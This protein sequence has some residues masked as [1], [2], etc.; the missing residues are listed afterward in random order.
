MKNKL[1]WRIV[2]NK[3]IQI[4]LSLIVIIVFSIMF[5]ITK[6]KFEIGSTDDPTFQN[7]SYLV[8]LFFSKPTFGQRGSLTEGYKSLVYPFGFISLLV[9]ILGGGAITHYRIQLL[10]HLLLMI[11]PVFY[12]CKRFGSLFIATLVSLAVMGTN[13]FYEQLSYSIG[14]SQVVLVAFAIWAVLAPS[15]TC[16]SKFNVVAF[17]ALSTSVSLWSNLPQLLSTWFTLALIFSIW[18]ACTSINRRLLIKRLSVVVLIAL[19]LYAPF[20]IW[21]YSERDFFLAAK[22]SFSSSRF[23][24]LGPSF[25]MQ[26]FGKWFIADPAW[27]IPWAMDSLVWYR[28]LIRFVFLLMIAGPLVV[29]NFKFLTDAN[30]RRSQTTSLRS[31]RLFFI[32]IMT[33]VS[34]CVFY[35][36]NSYSLKLKIVVVL[37]FSVFLVLDGTLHWSRNLIRRIASSRSSSVL[38]VKPSKFNNYSISSFLN[39]CVCMSFLSLLSMMGRWNW[40][41]IMRDHIAILLMFR[42]PW[43]KFAIPQIIVMYVL[44]AAVLSSIF[45]RFSNQL[46]KSIFSL[47]ILVIFSILLK[48]FFVTG[49]P[50]QLVDGKWV[51]Y[52][53]MTLADWNSFEAELNKVDGL[54]S[55]EY[56]CI[57]NQG[58]HLG[59]Q[60]MA[61]NR[62]MERSEILNVSSELDTNS[63]LCK[64]DSNSTLLLIS[65]NSFSGSSELDS[66]IGCSQFREKWILVVNTQCLL[67]Q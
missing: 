63:F 24:N 37:L 13:A 52:H 56:F 19:V 10:A 32:G 67:S 55:S 61:H 34:S 25:V 64:I 8:K 40:Y 35:F 65:N 44:L 33:L 45:Q 53:D 26:G 1:L 51:D 5:V 47:T 27:K 31:F 2:A 43:T 60:T 7:G 66:F 28:Q 38:P 29:I 41:W 46:S 58:R 23:S 17:V 6:T 22:Q 3:N 57:Y 20:I 9:E 21:M 4:A 11:I 15:D 48:P 59:F 39:L 50:Q 42:E 49:T 36:E 18:I 30:F 16:Q 12:V 14:A 62:F 54:F